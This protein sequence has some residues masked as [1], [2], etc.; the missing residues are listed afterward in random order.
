MSD[1]RSE[2]IERVG[3]G[4]QVGEGQSGVPLHK[5]QGKRDRELGDRERVGAGGQVGGDEA[6]QKKIADLEK[7]LHDVVEKEIAR[8]DAEPDMEPDQKSETR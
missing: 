6:K 5:P 4:G 1:D 7:A 2:R 8:G 3:A